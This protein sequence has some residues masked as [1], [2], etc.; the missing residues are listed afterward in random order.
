MYTLDLTNKKVNV[1]ECDS[2]PEVFVAG[3]INTM[4]TGPLVT[5]TFTNVRADVTQL[6]SGSATPDLNAVVVSRMVMPVATAEQLI[7]ALR[8]VVV[9]ASSAAGTA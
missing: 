6:M 7:R 4:R 2:V 8:D 1:K 9:P 3:P 5:I